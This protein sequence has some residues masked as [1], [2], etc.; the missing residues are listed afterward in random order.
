MPSATPVFP[1]L[2]HSGP[3]RL[4]HFFIVHGPALVWANRFI[5]GATQR[6]GGEGVSPKSFIF[7]PYRHAG[8][9][10]S[11]PMFMAATGACLERGYPKGL[12]LG[13][14]SDERGKPGPQILHSFAR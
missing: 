5:A 9:R 10:M 12:I 6:G 4:P 1:Q 8:N 3:D 14:Q 2:A 13:W 11:R 7:P